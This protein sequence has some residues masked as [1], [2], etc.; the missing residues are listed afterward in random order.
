MVA[1]E[2]SGGVWSG[3]KSISS[4]QTELGVLYSEGCDCV[5]VGADGLVTAYYFRRSVD[6]GKC[7]LKKDTAYTFEW[8]GLRYSS[9]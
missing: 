3:K 7:C 6:T 8:R 1:C 4:M 2:L 5:C 9:T